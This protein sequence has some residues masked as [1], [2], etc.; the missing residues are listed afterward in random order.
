MHQQLEKKNAKSNFKTFSAVFPGFEK[1]ESAYIKEVSEN[2]N[3]RNFQFTPTA[4]LLISEFEKMAYHQEEPFPSSSIY[5]QYK[6]FELAKQHSVKVLLDGQGADE[7]LAGYH[8]YVH[9]YLQE[10]ISRSQFLRA[11]KER[12]M[13]IEN[14]INPKWGL[15]NVLAALLPSHASIALE[16]AEYKR[17]IHNEDISKSLL[18]N[19]KGREWEGIHKPIITKLNDI[20]YFNTMSNGL[21][22]LLRYADRNSMAHGTE[23]RLPFLNAELVQFIFSL[24]SSFK[25][26]DGYP[27][28]VLRKLMQNKLP[29]SIVWRTDKIGYEPPQKAWMENPV[30][31]DYM[32]EAKKALV[33][34]DILKP[35]V[36]NKK[37]KPMDAHEMDNF[38]WRYLCVSQLM[39]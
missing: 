13:L 28:W 39:D 21:E 8:K 18:A 14:N 2:L 25:V 1:D 32:Q 15:K 30:L 20:L 33:K 22:E 11:K 3:I 35:A 5:A 12:H 38:N 23:V 19:L 7:I 17:I 26:K 34:K 27:K 16:K 6:V 4:D 31:K 24:P 36:L 9:W 10:I 29:D 37:I